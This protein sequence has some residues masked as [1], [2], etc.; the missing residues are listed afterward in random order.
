[1][2]IRDVLPFARDLNKVWFYFHQ[3]WTEF[4]NTTTIE[5]EEGKTVIDVE[6]PSV[7]VEQIIEYL[8]Y[9]QRYDNE[10]ENRPEFPIDLYNALDL[11]TASFALGC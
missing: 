9:K 4:G 6:Y 2:L 10:A 7:I 5:I 8:Y 11:M 3:I 1:M